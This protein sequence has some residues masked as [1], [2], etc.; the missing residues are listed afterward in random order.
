MV[1]GPRTST[2]LDA[3]IARVRAQTEEARSLAASDAEAFARR[4]SEDRWSGAEHVAHLVLTGA[5]YLETIDPS[6]VEARGYGHLSE[7]PFRG[8]MVGN[9]F[10]NAMAPPVKR[11]MRTMGKL[12]PAPDVDAGDALARYQAFQASFEVSLEAARGIDLDRAKMRSPFLWLLRMP[13]YSA[14]LVLLNHADRHLLLARE[15]MGSGANA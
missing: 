6:V 13:V 1:D 10:A 7:G 9:W 4:P 5:P 3:M 12:K 11:R 14:Y 2:Q 15:S 8:G